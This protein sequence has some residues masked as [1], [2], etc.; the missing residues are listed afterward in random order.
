MSDTGGR[1]R[2][3]RLPS[4]LN[5]HQGV[6]AETGWCAGDLMAVNAVKGVECAEKGVCGST[7]RCARPLTTKNR[8]HYAPA[9]ADRHARVAKTPTGRGVGTQGGRVVKD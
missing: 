7:P 9:R 8:G 1:G 2:L 6:D 5:A 3:F 4:Q